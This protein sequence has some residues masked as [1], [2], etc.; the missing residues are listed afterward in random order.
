VHSL[1]QKDTYSSQLMTTYSPPPTNTYSF[2][3]KVVDQDYTISP[4][5]EGKLF[6]TLLR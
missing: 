2:P 5:I 4:S 3:Q 6:E 1:P